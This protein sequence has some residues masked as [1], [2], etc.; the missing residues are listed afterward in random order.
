MRAL[1]ILV[2]FSISL[3]AV[4]GNAVSPQKVAEFSKGYPQTMTFNQFITA[5]QEEL[6][7]KFVEYLN[8]KFQ[9]V[10]NRELPHVKTAGADSLEIETKKQTLKITFLPN[11][12]IGLN[13]KVLDLLAAGNFEQQWNLIMK[14]LPNY[15]QAV[16][17]DAFINKAHAEN[18]ESLNGGL[19]MATGGMGVISGG[20]T[21][22]AEGMAA[23]PVGVVGA[24]LVVMVASYT[25]WNNGVCTDIEKERF[26]CL[27]QK[28]E[29]QEKIS[30]KPQAL[31]SLK[32]HRAPICVGL[33]Q[34]DFKEA[35]D[36]LKDLIGANKE[37]FRAVVT[38][39]KIKKE[40]EKCLE[41]TSLMAYHLCVKMYGLT[42]AYLPAY[43]KA[44]KSATTGSPAAG[45]K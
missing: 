7:E 1:L 45:K 17:F 9:K 5:H 38:C 31:A 3:N 30:H 18:L 16:L 14:S 44:G 27:Q 32:S 22:I 33:E 15:E 10:Q 21:I 8:Y 4:A 2:G 12:K 43:A 26:S 35:S 37:I 6:P 40:L 23:G 41:D 24:G 11:H 20:A 13:G 28:D 36:V 39:R 19:M 42:D 29:L 34:T 25:I